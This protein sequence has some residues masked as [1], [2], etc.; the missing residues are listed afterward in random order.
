MGVSRTIFYDGPSP[1][2]NDILW[3]YKG[4]NLQNYEHGN[5]YDK[6]NR[7][8]TS[9]ITLGDT[10]F[11]KMIMAK[12][13]Y[14]I[15]DGSMADMSRILAEVFKEYGT[16]FYVFNEGGNKYKVNIITTF[17]IPFV[18]KVILEYGNLLPVPAGVGYLIEERLPE[19][20]G[21]EGTGTPWDNGTFY[22]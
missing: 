3:G 15:T 2:D 16:G 14:N 9:N 5:F 1:E 18:L 19:N 22:E 12:A 11:R 10:S 13:A 21:F 4:S 20:F 8:T 6:D 17:T 7:I